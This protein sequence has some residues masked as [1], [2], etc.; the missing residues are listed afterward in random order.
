MHLIHSVPIPEPNS[1]VKF[2]LPYYNK[3][4][5]ITCP[6]IE[7]ISVMNTNTSTLLKV[8]SVEHIITIYKLILNEKKILFIDKYYERLAKVT[9]G[10]TSLLYPLQWIHTYIPIMSDQMLKYLE[11]FLPFLNGINESLMPLV[12]KIFV[13]GETEEDDEVFLI[14]IKTKENQ[15]R[16]SSSFNG[17]NKK[18]DKYIHDNIPSLPYS[19]EKELKNKLKKAKS[20]L[21]DIEKNKKKN[22]NENKQACELTIRDAFIELF[23]EMFQDYARYLSFI[24]QDPVFNKSLFLEKKSNN[25]KS[26]YNEILDTQLFQQFTQNVVNE[27]VNY[28]NNKIELHETKKKKQKKKLKILKEY[29]INPRFL[30][31]PQENDNETI[32]SLIKKSKSMYPESK[33]NNTTLILEN[34]LSI[35]D[36]K[37][38]EDN[39]LI[40]FT[41]EEIASK[42]EPVPLI[43]F[44]R[45][46][47]NPRRM[48]NSNVLQKL[49][50]MNL[51]SASSSKKKDG[52]SEKE[53]DMVKED[54]KDIVIKIFKSEEVILEKKETTELYNKLN[55]PFG[56]K[57]FISLL[58]KNSSNIILLNDNSAHFLWS[59]INELVLNTLKLEETDDVL[60][61]SVL[62][63]KSSTYFGIQEEGETK[64]LF[65]KNIPKILK[66]SKITQNNF[67]VII[68]T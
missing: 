46:T 57:F 47:R 44:D 24:E 16:L 21:D 63:I 66:F 28:F 59:L 12:E 30:N 32:I 62:L 35:E 39:C 27:D 22:T 36:K 41:P 49:K 19:L 31:I 20:E 58:I 26:F 67:Y 1:M 25:E 45:Q 5:E 10:F 48:T 65:D 43:Q 15:I 55:L 17:K 50:A 6:K 7:D 29:Y 3:R 61:D 68:S 38:D 54:I 23:V 40:Y 37:Y 64:T 42:E 8:F 60:E 14:Y 51:K 52:P 56:R 34:K 18:L 53:I 13:E 11:T 4:L 9:D 2:F 33:L